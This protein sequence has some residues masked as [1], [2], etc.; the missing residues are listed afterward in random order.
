MRLKQP[1]AKDKPAVR[2]RILASLAWQNLLHKK[3]RTSL[4]VA[5]IAV[6]IGAVYFLLSLGFGVQRLVVNEVVGNQSIRTIDVRTDNSKAV[7]INDISTERIANISNV[8][9]IGKSYFFPGNLKINNSENDSIIYGVN[10]GYENLTNLNL[11]KGSRLSDSKEDNPILLNK[12]SLEAMG[13][14]KDLTQVLNKSVEISIPLSKIKKDL[15]KLKKTFKVVGVIDS[16][17]GSE[18]FVRSD[19]F[20]GLGITELTQLK[21]GVND[22]ENV[23]TVRSQIE[24]LGFETS[25]PVD[26]LN[27]IN[28]VFQFINIIL[29]GFGGI[30]M[31]IAILGMFNTLTVSLLER[32]R[33]IGLMFAL[34]ARSIDMKRLFIFE[35]LLLSISGSIIGIIGAYLLGIVINLVMNFFASQRGVHEGFDLF[36]NPPILII[37]V[38]LFMIF[39]GLLVVVLP[40]R[41]AQKI[42]PIDALRRE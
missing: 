6:G 11:I 36:A 31:I 42:N 10:D 13:L 26:T 38:I 24:N 22:V 30:G 16:G 27:E 29:V 17:S 7:K 14:D 21:V 19:I 5:G 41:R 2:L 9:E 28:R 32:T 35:A 1:S 40:S 37:G 8:K 23:N 12:A 34:G 15:G 39:V 20:R 33:E 3:L 4:T 25:S 18:V